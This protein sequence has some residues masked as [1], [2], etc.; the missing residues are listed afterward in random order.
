MNVEHVS[1]PG[2]RW[3]YLHGF[4]S[5]PESAK[6]VALS[7]HYARYG[8]PLE[9]LNLRQ[10]SLEHLRLSAMM[11]TVREA[12]GGE[13]DRAILF[14]S[15]LGGLTACRVAE[16]DARVCALVLLAPALRAMEQL[17]RRAGEAGMRRWEQT[18]W[19]ETQ[20]YAEKRMVRVDFGFVPDLKAI[21]ARSGGWPD[22]RV[23]TLILHGRQD[24]TVDIHASRQ[25]ARGKRHVRLVEVDDGHELVASLGRITAEADDFLRPFL[26]PVGA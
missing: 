21:D 15:S 20:D 23:P 2:P 25:W 22:V 6:G 16:E 11:R 26:A 8:I 9:R 19:M 7:A 5:G 24:D 14:G 13:R 18:G 17:R 12:I 1:P 4:A 3:L 10:P